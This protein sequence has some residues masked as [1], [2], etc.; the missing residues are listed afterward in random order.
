MPNLRDLEDVYDARENAGRTCRPGE[1]AF[2]LGVVG[3]VLC[4]AT[5]ACV[6]CVR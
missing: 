1:R 2:L 4:L 3:M 6:G 5:A